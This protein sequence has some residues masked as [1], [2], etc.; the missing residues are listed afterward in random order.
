M[1]AWWVFARPDDVIL[2]GADEMHA[3]TPPDEFGKYEDMVEKWMK[4]GF[5]VEKDG[6]YVEV[7]RQIPPA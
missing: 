3:W 5:V 1:I 4:L 2:E 7:Q 6:K